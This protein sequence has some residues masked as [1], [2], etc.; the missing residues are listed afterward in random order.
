MVQGVLVASA[1]AMVTDEASF[2]EVSKKALGIYLILSALSQKACPMDDVVD[3]RGTAV[4]PMVSIQ[5]LSRPDLELRL[6]EF[7]QEQ[8]A[9]AN[10]LQLAVINANNRFVVSGKPSSVAVFVDH[11]HLQTTLSDVSTPSST[12]STRYLEITTPHH[13][14]LLEYIVDIVLSIVT[15]KGWVLNASDMRLPVYAPDDGQDIRKKGDLTRYLVESVCVLQVDWPQVIRSSAA[16]HIL[17]FGPGGIAGFGYLAYKSIEGSGVP[18]ICAGALASDPAYPYI[19]A[20]ADLYKRGLDVVASAPNWLAEFGPRLVRTAFDGNLH[21]DTRMSR[22]LGMPTLMV[23]GMTH[24]TSFECFVAAINNAGYHAELSGSHAYNE[25]ELSQ[26]IGELAK[27]TTPGQGIT[28][29]C[30]YISQKQWGYQLPTL[31]SL[32]KQGLPISGLC[33]GGGVPST[34][35]AATIVGSLREAGIFHV[36]FKPYNADSIRQVVSIAQASDGYPVLLQWTGSSSGGHHS[37]EDMHQPLLETYATIRS[38]KNIVL[39]VGSGFGDAAGTL[40]YITGGWSTRYGYAPMPVDGIL[41]GSR[42]MVAKEAPTSF[43]AKELIVAAPGISEE[44]WSQTRSE[45]GSGVTSLVSEYGESNHMLVNRATDFVNYLRQAV[46]DHPRSEQAKLLHQHKQEVIRGLNS[47]FARPWFGKKAGGK[48]VDLE[49]MTYAE[50]ISRLVE[51]TYVPHEQRWAADSYQTFV[52]KFVERAER[53]LGRISNPGD[54]I[55]S[56]IQVCSPLDYVGIVAEAY[57]ETRSQLIASEDMQYFIALWKQRGQKPLPFIAVLDQD[58]GDMLLKDTLWQCNDLESVVGQDPQRVFIQHGPVAAQYSTRADEPVKDILDNIYRAHVAAI[59]E[60][61]YSGDVDSVPTI[62]YLG[63]SHPGSSVPLHHVQTSESE[64]MRT[65]QL[66]DDDNKPLPDSNDWLEKLAGPNKSWMRALLTSSAIV[67]GTRYAPNIVQKLIRPR[68]GQRVTICLQDRVPQSL[69]ITNNKTGV[70]E[71]EIVRNSATGDIVLTIYHPV[72]SG[73]AALHLEFSYHPELPVTPIRQYMDRYVSASRNLYIQTWVDNSDTPKPFV[74]VADPSMVLRSSG[75][76]ITEKHVRAYCKNIGDSVWKSQPNTCGR[77]QVPVE[78]AFMPLVPHILSVFSSSLADGGELEIIQTHN[79]YQLFHSVQPVCIGDNVSTEM[80]LEECVNTSPGKLFTMSAKMYCNSVQIGCLQSSCL[81]RGNFFKPKGLFRRVRG[82]TIS[83]QLSSVEDVCELESKD[84]F[85]YHSSCSD[86]LSAGSVLEFC[87]DS[88]YEF[89]SE[90]T[91][92]RVASSGTA[93]LRKRGGG[94]LH[95]ANVEFEW[96]DCAGNPVIDYLNKHKAPSGKRIF[97]SGGYSVIKAGKESAASF[98]APSSNREYAILG[99]DY[100]PIHTNAYLADV[101]DL[102]GTLTHG[103]WTQSATR[104][105]VEMHAADGEMGRL[106]SFETEFT[107]MVLPNDILSV[108]VIHFGM[109]DGRMLVRGSTSQQEGDAV[110]SYTAEFEQPKTAYVFTGQGSQSAGMGMALYEQSAAAR[111]VWDRADKHMVRN[112]GISLLNIVRENPARLDIRLRGKSGR[113]VLENYLSIQARSTDQGTQLLSG[114][115]AASKMHTFQSPSGLLNATQF[116]QPAL[117]VLALAHVADM[118][119]KGLVQKHAVFAGHSLGELAALAALGSDL[120]TVEEIVDITFYRGLLMQSAIVRDADGYSGYSMVSVNPLRI[121]SGFDEKK[122]RLA[123]DAIRGKYPGLLEIA[124]HNIQGQ[125]YIVSGARLQLVALRAVLDSFSKNTVADTD[126]SIADVVSQVLL[127]SSEFMALAKAPSRI[128]NRLLSGHA[129]VPLDGIDVPFHSSMLLPCTNAFRALLQKYILPGHI[130]ISAL[131]GC[132]IP[133]LTGRPFEVTKEYFKLVLDETHSPV[134]GKAL[135]TWNADSL[136]DADALDRLAADLLIEL[137]SFQLASPVQWSDTLREMH[138]ICDVRQVIEIGTSPILCSMAR[139]TIAAKKYAIKPPAILHIVQDRDEIY[140]LDKISSSATTSSVDEASA[141]ASGKTP[142][143]AASAAAISEESSPEPESSPD[144]SSDLPALS[145]DASGSDSSTVTFDDMPPQAI[146]VILAIIA[147]KFKVPISDIAVA[148]SIK[149]LAAGTSTLQNEL[150]GDLSKEFSGKLPNKAEE[151]A[152]EELAASL[153]SFEGGLGKHTQTRLTRMFSSK[154][155]GGFS[156]AT[157]RDTLQSAYGFGPHRQD[158]VLLN[159]VASEPSSRLASEADAISW[160]DGLA[161]AYAKRAGISLALSKQPK[162]K[163]SA[164]IPAVSSAALKNFE[165]KQGELFQRQIEV[166]AKF[167]GVDLNKGGKIAQSEKAKFLDAQHELDQL[168]NELGEE[169]VY[170]IMPR[171]EVRKARMF[172]SCWNWVRQ[173]VFEWIQERLARGASAALESSEACHA[174][175]DARLHRV[176]NCA[177]SNLLKLLAG[178]VAILQQDKESAEVLSALELAQQLY[179]ACKGSLEYLP[180]YKE[181]ST[182]LQPET[183]VSAKGDVSYREIPRAGE[184]SFVE[185]VQS[186][187]SVPSKCDAITGTRLPPFYLKEK[188]Q[189]Q[190]WEYSLQ[191]SALYYQSLKDIAAGGLSFAGKTAI[192][193]GCGNGSIGAEIVRGLLMGGAKV[194]ATTSSYSYQTNRFF[195]HMY[196]TCGSRGS[197]LIVVPF[198]QGSV[199]DIK[200]LINYA[201]D[202]PDSSNNSSLGWDVDYVFPFAAI[203]DYGVTATDIGSRTELSQRIML[204]NVIRMVGGIKAKKERQ[205]SVSSPSLVVL[206]LSPNHGFIGG[207]GL[208]GEC[209]VA[210][211][212]LVNRWKSESWQDYISIAGAVMGWVRGTAL[213]SANNLV[214]QDVEKA[215]VRTFSACEM[216]FGIFGLLSDSMCEF[217]EA[218]PVWAVM[219]SGMGHEK[220]RDVVFEAHER[221]KL[222]KSVRSKVEYGVREDYHSLYE[223]YPM[224]SNSIYNLPTPLANHRSFFPEPKQH[225]KLQHLQHLQD[226]VNLDKVVVITGYGEVGPYGHAETRW[227]VEAFGE[228]TMEGCIELGWIMGIIKH[229]N[230][231][232]PGSDRHYVGWVDTKSGQPVKDAD[233]K[234][235]YHDHIMKH[236]GIRPI[237][238]SVVHGYDPHNKT[239]MREV[240]IQH[241][242]Q[243]FEAST[244]D[245]ASFKERNSDKVDIWR[246]H[247]SDRWYVQ[248]LK[249]ALIRVPVSVAD[250]KGLVAGMIPTGWDAAHFGVPQDVIKQIDPSTLYLVVAAAEALVRS[251]FTDPYELY[252]HFHVSEVGNALGSAIGSCVSYANAFRERMFETDMGI[253]C[254]QELLISTAQAWVNM[255]LLSGAG[256]VLPVV[257]ACATGVLSINAAAEAIQN[258]KAKVMMAGA[259]D[260]LHE[261]I[262]YEFANMGALADNLE[263]SANGRIPTES[264]RPCTTTRMGLLESHGAGVVVLMSASAAIQCGAPIYGIVG[265]SQMASDKQGRSVPAPGQGILTFAKESHASSN[266]NDSLRILDIYYRRQ[267]LGRQLA[268]LD[269]M[270]KQDVDDAVTTGHISQIKHEY[271]LQRSHAQNIWGNEFWKNNSQISPVRGNLSV[272]GL[273]VD[274]IG[275]AYFHGTS[276]PA[277]D[278]NESEVVNAQMKHLGRTPG[279]VV[280]VVCQKWLTGHPKGP[281]AMFMLNGVLQCLRTGIIPGNRNADN[282][283]SKLKKYDYALYMSKSIQ[284]PGIKAAMLTSFGF[285][286]VGGELLIIHPDYLLATLHHNELN[287]YNRKL[288]VNDAKSYRYWQDTLIGNHPFVQVKDRPP[289]SSKDEKRVYLDPKSR[290]QFNSSTNTY[291]FSF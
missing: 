281:A 278:V 65:F 43:A 105:V 145:G 205:G 268:F 137:L 282:I 165:Q 232:L 135:E 55:M 8:R 225:Q 176:Q 87:L 103:L 221:I 71:V 38:C 223:E 216:A 12:I 196:K 131:S 271:Q 6:S 110:L 147:Q 112:Y 155:P 279:N 80:L 126:G 215:G 243:P 229:F 254:C 62:E 217:A 91:Y 118:R 52:T 288:A 256:P 39:V 83:V 79:K 25:E 121:G 285:G 34:E 166:L 149:A 185:F 199:Q 85:V 102:P 75:F 98:T 183:L 263:D 58:F 273:S 48:V 264:C 70:V 42:V 208:Y 26:K 242:M 36:S 119:S 20:R 191:E 269:T 259:V 192:V 136:S 68:S 222:Q 61:D 283:D 19:G 31:L 29:N 4:K 253:D 111:D 257:G 113:Q 152:L 13:C 214:S 24:T 95:I 151:L 178:F 210:L 290:A 180:T 37:A 237:E 45:E 67:R 115:T 107:R 117:A 280:P 41:L 64:S 156:L 250:V 104:A 134:L 109:E 15:E 234:L 202:A 159:A 224:F 146:D 274:D 76:K 49:D 59:L 213:M 99:G 236:S 220:H 173:D 291:E 84:W 53:R 2:Y 160:L 219:D 174:T 114:L 108:D 142:P 89:K 143:A 267:K 32:R 69:A 238:P 211:E 7:N 144:T 177:D 51:L 170:G 246:D 275:L 21:I 5:G 195:E 230:G 88:T 150:I 172:D 138:S 245:A 179:D 17:D 248:F 276:T 218:R 247:G 140:Y 133:N 130:D 92:S 228:L 94:L 16:L 33:I 47:D 11:L 63:G 289:F 97:E 265:M 96:L 60:R 186:I 175:L 57:P 233:I 198:N 244:E 23:A 127:G 241:D 74:D 188:R 284:T 3:A 72:D 189:D 249:G 77:I 35:A 66:P 158:A 252:S 266:A 86:K 260:D 287:E 46:L 194:L 231:M 262:M 164:N 255:L 286:Q 203:A 187:Q 139:K 122:L 128:S 141:D 124:N 200:Q 100:N 184:P 14:K 116:T 154:M 22:V 44:Q 1:F 123:I 56:D 132:Y 129:T 28:L 82:E 30:I 258:G 10:H 206:P 171:F 9:T 270:E 54:S 190:S 226:M 161:K 106:R 148:K 90:S 207:D 212:T 93:M 73:R 193:T 227:E 197:E 235:R 50:V 162:A 125:Q 27:M 204:T 182:P 18:I 120:L 168:D 209:K 261:D 81:S 40:P 277:N 153:T 169:L 272:W 78:Y 251:G 240:Q 167:S 157:A 163:Q 239:A 181:L 101:A 201:F